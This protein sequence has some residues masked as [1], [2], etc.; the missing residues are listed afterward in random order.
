MVTKVIAILVSAV[1][2]YDQ[3]LINGNVFSAIGACIVFIGVPLLVMALFNLKS[4]LRWKIPTHAWWI[5]IVA[6]SVFWG[7]SIVG[8][9][10]L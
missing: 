3:W 7:L 4:T 1:I 2:F 9:G 6:S 8:R 10:G 5:Y